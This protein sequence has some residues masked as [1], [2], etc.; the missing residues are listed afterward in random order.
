MTRGPRFSVTDYLSLPGG[1]WEPSKI[2]D[3]RNALGAVPEPILY[4]WVFERPDSLSG[5]LIYHGWV[6]VAPIY[7]LISP[8]VRADDALITDKQQLSEQISKCRL[9][10][11][12]HSGPRLTDYE[13]RA[14]YHGYPINPLWCTDDIWQT[15]FLEVANR[16][17]RFVIDITAEDYAAGLTFELEH[18]FATVPAERMVLLMDR[19]RADEA[20]ILD[21]LQNFWGETAGSAAVPPPIVAYNSASPQYLAR[22]A[23]SQWTGRPSIPIAER[24][25][26]RA[27]W[28]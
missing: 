18:L 19:F 16:V 17:H 14:S 15:A 13:V 2:S 10:T 1:N 26:T 3:S 5:Q 12:T 9:D 21:F 4:L 24:A 27:G 7:L 23:W 22:A 28:L 8:D 25:A 6:Q 11:G 20:A